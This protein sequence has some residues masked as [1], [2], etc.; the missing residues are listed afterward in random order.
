MLAVW[1]R[2]RR[3]LREVAPTVPDREATLAA[4]ERAAAGQ[5]SIPGPRAVLARSA[6]SAPPIAPDPGS[7]S[8]PVRAGAIDP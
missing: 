7:V 8:A 3:V 4:V 6:R 1:L 5:S 2:A